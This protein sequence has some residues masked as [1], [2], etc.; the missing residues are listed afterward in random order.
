[1]SFFTLTLSSSALSRHT[2]TPIIPLPLRMGEGEDGGPC[3]EDLAKFCKDVQPG[4]GRI[5]KCLKEHEKELSA[6]CTQHI[7]EVQSRWKEANQAC[8][9]DV[10]KFCKDVKPDGFVK[11]QES[12]HS[13]ESSPAFGGMDSRFR[14]NDENDTKRTFYESIKPGKG[15]IGR[16]LKEHQNELSPECQGKLAQPR[17][18]K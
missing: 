15:R 3:A 18:R 1:M 10:L 2:R 16:C 8:H 9:D 17:K 13:C 6:T 7:A 14:G 5:A 4:G 12:R 11:S